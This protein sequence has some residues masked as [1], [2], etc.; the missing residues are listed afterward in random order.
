MKRVTFVYG[1]LRIFMLVWKWNKRRGGGGGTFIRRNVFLFSDRG[2]PRRFLSCILI[3]RSSFF[4]SFSP[5]PSFFPF[6]SR[7]LSS[8][9]ECMQKC[10]LNCVSW[11]G[12]RKGALS[13]MSCAHLSPFLEHLSRYSSQALCTVFP[14]CI[15]YV[16]SDDCL[17]R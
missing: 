11:L 12:R 1:S 9:F 16:T 17:H 8:R 15:R 7:K 13:R 4:L 6:S 2:S 5:F 10:I 3:I 14:P